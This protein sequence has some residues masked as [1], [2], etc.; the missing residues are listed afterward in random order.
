MLFLKLTQRILVGLAAF[1]ALGSATGALAM[2]KHDMGRASPQACTDAKLTAQYEFERART[3]GNV[4]PF[5]RWNAPAE[6]QARQASAD[7]KP[8]MQPVADAAAPVVLR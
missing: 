1:V 2:E 7:E 6:C 8:A 4:N 3:D 5:F